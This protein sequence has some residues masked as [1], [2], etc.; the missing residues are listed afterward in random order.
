MEQS[1]NCCS[2][3][4]GEEGAAASV[5]NGLNPLAGLTQAHYIKGKGG[6]SRGI[7]AEWTQSTSWPHAGSLHQR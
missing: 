3:G 2:V 4:E 7:C 5:R 6:G 1:V